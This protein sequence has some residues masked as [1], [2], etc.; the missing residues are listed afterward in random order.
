MRHF[1]LILLL[2]TLVLKSHV[3]SALE[4][5]EDLSRQHNY[6][7]TEKVTIEELALTQKQVIGLERLRVQLSEPISPLFYDLEREQRELDIL[8]TSSDASPSEIREKY[9]NVA[10]LRETISR[11]DFEYQ[12][13]IRSLLRPEQI[14]PYNAYIKQQQAARGNSPS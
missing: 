4:A 8:I 2:S 12:M 13:A 14:E 1:S 7:A 3:A 6:V 10:A 11:L 9:K 5:N